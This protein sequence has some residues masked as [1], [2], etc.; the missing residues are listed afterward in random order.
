MSLLAVLNQE[1]FDK[2]SEPLKAEYK[3]QQDGT[4]LLD[5]SPVND[6]ALENVK[7]LKTALSSERATRERLE[8][9]VKAFEGLDP[10]KAKEALEKLEKLGTGNHDEKTKAEIEALKKQLTEKHVSEISKRD[11]SISLMTKQ[12]EK[13]LVESAAVKA[14]SDNKGVVELL[15]PHVRSFTRMKRLDNGEYVVE[16]VDANGNVRIT[17]K[18]G[19]TDPMSIT[20]LVSEMK[21]NKIYSPAFQ[22]S[23]ANGSGSHGGTNGGGGGSVDYVKMT[24]QERMEAAIQ[25][26]IN[27]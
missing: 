2:L 18:S 17:N 12:I 11:E 14:I 24:P 1:A 13:L 7:G 5:V 22:G 25:N 23:G 9:T 15:L 6:F 8:N 27:K 26:G 21:G 3:K 20:E 10:V 19:S 4:F 16:V